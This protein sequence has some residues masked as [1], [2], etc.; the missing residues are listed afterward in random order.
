MSPPTFHTSH[1]LKLHSFTS[2]FHRKTYF[3]VTLLLSRLLSLGTLWQM[4]CI[5]PDSLDLEEITVQLLHWM[6]FLKAS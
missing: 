2:Y 3:D 5:T 1:S 6:S 4:L